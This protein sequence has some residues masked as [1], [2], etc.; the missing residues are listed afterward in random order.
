MVVKVYERDVELD[1]TVASFRKLWRM[2]LFLSR[3]KGGDAFVSVS[4][5]N[6]TPP[7]LHRI[8]TKTKLKISI[9]S[10]DTKKKKKKKNH[11][12]I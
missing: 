9:K 3:P 8:K 2:F 4:L 10:I 12:Y 5:D 6:P 1:W 11:K 7:E